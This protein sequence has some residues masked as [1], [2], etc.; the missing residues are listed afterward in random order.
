MSVDLN[1]WRYKE[2]AA[3]D[4]HSAVYQTVCCGGAL[5]EELEPLPI[6]EILEKVAAAFSGW[7][8]RNQGRD[9]EKPGRGAFQIDTTPQ[10]VRFDCSGMQAADMNALTDLLIEF[11]CPLYDPQ[12]STRF[13]SWT[14]R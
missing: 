13:D 5:M 2:N 7:T 8:V 1:F 11:G 14:D 9:F 6:G 12:I 4:D 3:R 10:T